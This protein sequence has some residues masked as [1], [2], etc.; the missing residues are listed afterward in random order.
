MVMQHDD[1]ERVRLA[2]RSR[3]SAWVSWAVLI[4]PD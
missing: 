4:P 2:C 3:S 1:A